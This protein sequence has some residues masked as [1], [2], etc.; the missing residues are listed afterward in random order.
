MSFR[1]ELRN[2]SK[3]FHVLLAILIVG[4]AIA[5]KPVRLLS[6]DSELLFSF[7]INKGCAFYTIHYKGKQLIQPSSLSLVFNN[8]PFNKDLYHGPP[9]YGRGIENYMLVAGKR[10]NIS[11]T[12]TEM[13]IPIRQKEKPFR[14]VNLRVRAFHKAV[15]FRFEFPK[16]DTAS[17]FL[18]QEENTCFNIAGDPVVRT[19][20][21]PNYTTSHEGLYTTVP[22]SRIKE[23][24]LMDMPAL[25][26]FPSSA[27]M[28]ITEASLVDYAGMYLSKVNGVLQSRLS[29]WPSDSSIKVK[30]QLPH[31]SPWRVFLI[32]ERIGDL[33]ESTVITSLNEPCR[34]LDTTWIKPGLTTFPWWNGNVVPDTVVAPGN[35]FA[36]QQHYIDFCARNGILYHTVVEYGQRPWYIDDGVG[37]QPGPN[38]DVTKPVPGLDM[39]AV[40][41]YASKKGVGVRVWVH[42]AALYPKLD[43]A[44]A[45]FERWG[46]RGMMV[47]FMDRDDQQM[48]NMQ[49][50]MLQKA[51]AHRLHIQF[52]GTSKPTGINRT[53][54]NELTREAALNYEHN[55]WS[56]QAITPAHNLDIVFTRMLAGATDYHMGG[57]RAVTPNKYR[58][59]YTRPL[60][61]GTRAHML[62]MYV[63]LENYLGMV[64][65]Y[66]EA[67]EGEPGFDFVKQVPTTWDD[68]KV[69][70]GAPGE[71]VT[72]ARRKGEHWFVGGITNEKERTLQLP[73]SFLEKGGYRMTV[74]SDGRDVKWNPNSIQVEQKELTNKDTI[75]VRLESG[76]GVAITIYKLQ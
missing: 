34:M 17:Q 8:K 1:R 71:F 76:G 61:V 30:A 19:L 33:M 31:H 37:F 22:L 44:F 63:V 52:H 46:L 58:G 53:F 14:S 54:P 42:W 57:F 48:V 12:Y 74:Y 26:T 66:P 73:L 67:Y 15:A 45:L 18:I 27:Y 59:Q 64:C 56:N 11:D 70:D 38:A 13:L 16:N 4:T 32:S 43:S 68:T 60:V 29:P 50:E 5:Q 69:L 23:G 41:D 39:K 49:I 28:A 65:D 55:K 62:S 7:G 24:Q 36:T 3:H 75:S 51:A 72:I 2:L 35:N 20:V 40:C 47:D 10:K 9:V 21:L 25:F 6:P